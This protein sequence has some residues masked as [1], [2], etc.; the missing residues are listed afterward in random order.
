MTHSLA[1][2]A[3]LCH[4]SKPAVTQGVRRGLL[5]KTPDGKIDDAVPINALYLAQHTGGAPSKPAPKAK[6]AK[7][8]APDPDDAKFQKA[9]RDRQAKEVEV[10]GVDLADLSPAERKQLTKLAAAAKT[11]LGEVATLPIEKFKADIALKKAMTQLHEFKLAQNKKNVISRD[12]FR[13]I[14][15]AWNANLSQSVMRVPRRMSARLISM[16]RAG[17]DKM[18]IELE[19]ERALSTAVTRALEGVAGAS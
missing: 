17:K 8:K 6:S 11:D 1:S 18:E 15:E 3:A 12:E 4:V 19:L 5:T 10:D 14:A 2:W 7:A 16:V 9:V 13:R